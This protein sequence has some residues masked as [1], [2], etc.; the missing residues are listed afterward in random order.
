MRSAISRSF[1]QTD[2]Y[3]D[4][5]TGRRCT[6]MK[7]HTKAPACAR[8]HTHLRMARCSGRQPFS[9]ICPIAVARQSRDSTSP[10]DTREVHTHTIIAVGMLMC[11]RVANAAA[12]RHH[13]RLHPFVESWKGFQAFYPAPQTPVR[14]HTPGIPER[15]HL[16]IARTMIDRTHSTEPY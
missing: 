9:F 3:A 8:A 1:L 11:V 2:R 5:Q 16:G 14:A 6:D 12:V 4:R 7:T 10:S 15:R 13:C